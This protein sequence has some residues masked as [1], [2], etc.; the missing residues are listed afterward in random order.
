MFSIFFQ[1]FWELKSDGTQCRNSHHL[2]EISKERVLVQSWL[3]HWTDQEVLNILGDLVK[4]TF[5]VRNRE[6]IRLAI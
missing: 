4:G 2:K 5:A 3:R 6:I 1:S